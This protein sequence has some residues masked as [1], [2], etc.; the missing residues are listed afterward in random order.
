M[1]K[2]KLLIGPSGSGKTHRLLNDFEQ[3]LRQSQSPLEKDFY[4]I[5]PT[6]E[7]TERVISLI[8]QKGVPGFFHRRV[9]TLPRLIAELFGIHDQDVANNVTRYL[10]FRE[11]C[12]KHPW[13]YF[14]EVQQSPGFLNLML[15][16]ITEL[17]ES[18]VTPALFRERLQD[19]KRLELDLT[20][21]YEALSG[22]YEQYEAVLEAQGLRDGSDTFGIFQER[23]R[24]KGYKPPVVK[25]IWLHGFFDFSQIPLPPF[26]HLPHPPH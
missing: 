15:S 7:H 19:L 16:F 18:M 25:K 9:T 14:E 11:I 8:L 22:L 26:P 3:A 6:A 1:G 13:P 21:K 17:K 23:K 4:F 12:E 24:Q 2:K 5:L 20:P 10:I